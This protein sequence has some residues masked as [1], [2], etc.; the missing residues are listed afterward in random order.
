MAACYQYN[1]QQQ[2]QQCAIHAPSKATPAL[3]GTRFFLIP[4]QLLILNFFD[5]AETSVSAEMQHKI[6]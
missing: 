5:V 4:V 3:D 6:Y 2:Q 1:F